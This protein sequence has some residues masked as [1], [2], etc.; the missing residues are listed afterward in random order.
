MMRTDPKLPED[1]VRLSYEFFRT[2]VSPDQAGVT[3]LR[4]RLVRRIQEELEHHPAQVR[5]WCLLGDVHNEKTQKL[6]CYKRA[7][8]AEPDDPEANSELAFLYAESGDLGLFAVH[9]DDAMQ[10]SGGF[11]LESH[12]I[13]M[14]M[15]AA[16]VAEDN[17]RKAEA[18]RTGQHRFPADTL[19]A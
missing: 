17:N 15:D 2:Q 6:R 4:K 9:F 10:G 3:I 18:R 8:A 16:R 11:E 14:C 7:V 1:I 13:Y 5:L 12:V 19:F